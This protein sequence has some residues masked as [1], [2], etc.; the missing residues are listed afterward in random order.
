MTNTTD[1]DSD[2]YQRQRQR[3]MAETFGEDVI[4]TEDQP[5][6]P[7]PRSSAKQHAHRM[8]QGRAEA[9]HRRDLVQLHVQAGREADEQAHDEVMRRISKGQDISPKLAEA[10]MRHQR[11]QGGLGLSTAEQLAMGRTRAQG[12]EDVATDDDRRRASRRPRS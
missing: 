10:A 9:A 12:W 7:G 3:S 11:Q 4:L 5:G 6:P 1:M 8:Q 2:T